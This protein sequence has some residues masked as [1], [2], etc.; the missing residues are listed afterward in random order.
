MNMDSAMRTNALYQALRYLRLSRV[1]YIMLFASYLSTL[2]RT[3]YRN[4]LQRNP[5]AART[6]PP[7]PQQL[8]LD[9]IFRHRYRQR[10]ESRPNQDIPNATRNYK[11][12]GMRKVIYIALMVLWA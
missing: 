3:L 9:S 7:K 4:Q 5:S 12:R 8:L 10:I 11:G 2:F 1:T 6:P